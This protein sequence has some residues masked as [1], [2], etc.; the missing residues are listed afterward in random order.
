M[1]ESELT[2]KMDRLKAADPL[3]WESINHPISEAKANKK[4]GTQRIP[5]SR[6]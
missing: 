2:K 4:Y 3:L 1:K 6:C 5:K